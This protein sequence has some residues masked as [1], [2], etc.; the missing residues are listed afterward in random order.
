[1]GCREIF[2]ESKIPSSD[3]IAYT[4]FRVCLRSTR[5]SCIAVL[6]TPRSLPPA[7]P[8]LFAEIVELSQSLRSQWE[9]EN[10]QHFARIL[11]EL[12]S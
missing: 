4:F 10:P 9:T 5:Q 2:W 3:P 1:M 6:D 8:Q 7:D 12:N 11:S